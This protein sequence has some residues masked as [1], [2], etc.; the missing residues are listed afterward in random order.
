MKGISKRFEDA[1]AAAAFAEAGEFE[2][3]REIML[4]DVSLAEQIKSLKREV[5]TTVDDLTSMAIT[6]A[7]AGEQ[8][9]ALEI[10]K[11]A[12]KRLDEIK[13]NFKKDLL[14]PAMN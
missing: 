10:L 1:M 4:E 5:D 6:F 11:E 12:E 9:K 2:S 3:A 8:D 14:T 13:E 7:E